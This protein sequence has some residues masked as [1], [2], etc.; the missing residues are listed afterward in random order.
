[1]LLRVAGTTVLSLALLASTGFSRHTTAAQD[2]CGV[3]EEALQETDKL[4]P[5]MTRDKVEASFVLDGGMQFERTSRYTFKKCS[6]IKVDVEFAGHGADSPK[7]F[8]ATDRVVKVSRPYVAYP[9]FD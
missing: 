4:K 9:T 2:N 5:G 1:M 6:F 8:V 7:E 3:I